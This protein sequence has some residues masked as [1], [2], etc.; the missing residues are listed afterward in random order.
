[1]E[2]YASNAADVANIAGPTMFTLASAVIQ[3]YCTLI[4]LLAP[5]GGSVN[6]ASPNVAARKRGLGLFVTPYP[7]L[8]MPP[9]PLSM[10]PHLFSSCSTLAAYVPGGSVAV[11]RTAPLP[12]LAR[13]TSHATDLRSSLGKPSADLNT[14]KINW[15]FAFRRSFT[16]IVSVARGCV[17]GWEAGW[18]V[19][20]GR[21]SA[22][23]TTPSSVTTTTSDRDRPRIAALYEAGSHRTSSSLAASHWRV[24]YP[25]RIK[26]VPCRA[27]EIIWPATNTAA[28]AG[29][30]RRMSRRPWITSSSPPPPTPTSRKAQR[31]SFEARACR[32]SVTR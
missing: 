15:P 28:A 13:R 2:Q 31:P 22:A 27:E 25:G 9:S 11:K 4:V 19:D 17:A 12:R 1:M 3:K 14:P 24:R 8:G 7:S 29:P 21:L 5:S 32:P 23:T 18:E 20:V 16:S 26:C 10:L 30:L 6:V